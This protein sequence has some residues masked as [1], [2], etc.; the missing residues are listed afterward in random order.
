MDFFRNFKLLF[1]LV[2]IVALSIF[3]WPESDE[4]YL[5]KTTLKIIDLLVSPLDSSN[6]ASMIGRM[7]KITDPIHF[8]VKFEVFQNEER[9]FKRES[10]ASLRSVI[11]AYFGAKDKITLEAV[12]EENLVVQVFEEKEK[13]GEVSFLITGK[14]QGTDMSCQ[15]KM[16]WKYEEKKW[17]IYFI[18]A[19]ECQGLNGPFF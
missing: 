7:R 2:G 10:E 19:S 12:K 11:G 18:K 9:V 14:V 3:L 16:D 17:Y 1:F 15:V 5:K 13:R 8:S 4:A 6:K